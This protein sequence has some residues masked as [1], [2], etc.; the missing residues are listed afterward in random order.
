MDGNKAV[1]IDGITKKDYDKNLDKNVTFP[2]EPP[3]FMGVSRGEELLDT[4]HPLFTTLHLGW[5][6]GGSVISL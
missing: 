5:F 3:V 6:G 1:G 2:S 4:L